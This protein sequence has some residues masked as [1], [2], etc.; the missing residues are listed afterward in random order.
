VELLRKEQLSRALED[1]TEV[2]KDLR[3]LLELLMSENRAKRIESEKARIASASNNSI[4]SSSSRR[5]FK[6]APPAPTI[7]NVWPA[8][9]ERSPTNRRTGKDVRNSEEQKGKRRAEDGGGRRNT[10]GEGKSE[11]GEAERDQSENP[12][13]KRL[14]AAEADARS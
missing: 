13:T 8:S 1:Q 6:A 12:L 9:K 3:A 14:E 11:K 7:Q 10:E 5:T 4:P 2:D